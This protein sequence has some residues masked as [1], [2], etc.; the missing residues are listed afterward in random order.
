G[1]FAISVTVAAGGIT[2]SGQV[3]GAT[4][5]WDDITL[6]T[7]ADQLNSD[8]DAVR[9]SA[10]STAQSG[11]AVSLRVPGLPPGLSYDAESQQIVGTIALSSAG[12]GGIVIYSV[13]IN[14]NAGEATRTRTF[15]WSVAPVP[16][17]N[18]W[19]SQN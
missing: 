12:S 18:N 5:A 11:A 1:A 9:L 14:A 16:V 17:I 3:G 6:P 15:E 19:F 8:G 7:I 10:A 13:T 2:T 4:F